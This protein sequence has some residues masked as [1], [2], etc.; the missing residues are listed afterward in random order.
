MLLSTSLAGLAGCGPATG[1]WGVGG[2]GHTAAAGRARGTAR[3]VPGVAASAG[4]LA[5]QAAVT[6]RAI[7]LTDA[8]SLPEKVGQLF[9]TTVPGT[10]ASDGGAALIRTYHL[11]GVIYFPVNIHTAAQVAT[12]SNGL[13]Q[14]ALAHDHGVP[15]LIGT[16]QEGGIV[17]RLNGLATEFPDQMAAGATRDTALIRAEERSTAQQMRALGINLDYAPVAD[18]NVNPANPIIGIRSFGA[19]PSLVSTMTAAAVAGF[20]AGGVAATAKHFPGHGDTNVDSHTGLPVIHHSLRQWWRVDAP[21][22][23]AAIKAGVDE[24]MIAHIVV[25]ALDNSGLPASLSHR[26]VTG[27]LRG[28]LGYQGVVTTDSLQMAGVLQGRTGAQA[29]VDAI[30]AGCDQLLMPGSLPAAYQAVL[31]A[32]RD[33]RISGAR[34]N[35]SVT[36][37]IELKLRRGLL[38]HPVVDAA[39]AAARQNTPAARHT[40]QQIANRSVTVVRNRVVTGARRILPLRGRRVYLADPGGTGLGPALAAALAGTGGTLV[41]APAAA[42]VIVVATLNAG[43]DP[44]QRALVSS[45]ARTGRPLV[46]VATGV[47]YDLGLFPGAAAAVATYSAAPVSLTAAAGVLAGRVAPSGR[48]PVSIPRQDG[49]VLYRAGTGR[50]Y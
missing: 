36:R 13:Q 5:A 37:I 44:A 28:R 11:G 46:I 4:S 1:P 29:A 18:V 43:T 12:L 6:A 14:A 30:S 9:V 47:P 19:Q 27:Y 24:I 7:A 8:M 20:H 39:A 49:R 15:L 22:F 26:I 21:P 38:L 25:P 48:L 34:L 31:A 50:R 16:D 3:P 23:R 41:G 45:L 42:D 10:G 17:A 40:A 35:A 32:V 33:G 2:P